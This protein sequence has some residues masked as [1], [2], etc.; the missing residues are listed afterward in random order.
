VAEHVCPVW[1]GHLLASPIRKWLQH[2]DKLLGPYL[3]PG[4]LALD[5][6]SA[7]GFF[8][9]PMARRVGTGGKVVCVDLQ[10]RMLEKLAGRARRAGLL[11]RLELRACE[12]E[13]LGIDDLRGR[14]DLA[15]AFAMVHESRSPD[16]LLGQI[17]ASLKPTGRLFL[18][19]PRGHVSAAA[20]QATL[21]LSARQG[22]AVVE[23][24]RVW[25]SRA[26]LLTRPA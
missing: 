15:L 7:M 8:S 14:V 22:L 26:A 12:A 11:E 9:L 23:E 3:A 4:A 25:R 24:P 21:E 5:V 16:R 6:G 17:A 13:D 18:A 20:F 2:P 10:P 19:E 1:V